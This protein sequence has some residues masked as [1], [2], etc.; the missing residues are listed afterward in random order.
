[1]AH[2]GRRIFISAIA[3]LLA[4]PAS[5]AEIQ[6]RTEYRVAL[7]GLPIARAAFLTQIED[8]HSYKIAGDINSAGLADLITTISA[9]TSVTG[10]LRNDRLQAL[11]YSL[12]Y[13][14]GKKK[15]RVYEVSYRNGN[16]I[17]ATTTPA[18]KRPKNWIDV[19]PRDMRSVL[20]PISGLVFTGDTKV[21]SQTLPIFDGETRMDLVLSPKG[22]EDF[23][24]NGF[25]GKAIVCSVRFVPRSGYKKGRKDIDY[26][27]KS[28]RMEIWF[29][30][31]DA[32]NVYAPVYV[33]I[34]TQYGMVTITAVKY[35]NNS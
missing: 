4:I 15:A 13:K 14:S 12:Y 33:R 1:M 27:S 29:A 3:A 21:C 30:K 17:S 32:A 10:V 19:T 23:S 8:D 35:G 9:K 18:P 2:S 24:T 31:S 16:I 28:N 34:P 6:H 5:A 20:D 22:D 7:A 26:L 11:K 25:K